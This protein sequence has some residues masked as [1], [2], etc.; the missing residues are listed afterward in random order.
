MKPIAMQPIDL[1]YNKDLQII[2]ISF[3]FKEFYYLHNNKINI[4]YIIIGLIN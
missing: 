1:K 2:K 3:I 4:N